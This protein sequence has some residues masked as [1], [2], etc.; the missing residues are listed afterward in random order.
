MSVVA[1]SE[2]L[3]Y[4]LVFQTCSEVTF[5]LVSFFIFLSFPKLKVR[6]ELVLFSKIK[7]DI[8]SSRIAEMCSKN[9]EAFLNDI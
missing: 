5:T 2:I 9:A 1:V 7:S 6:N 4:R 3:A 8:A